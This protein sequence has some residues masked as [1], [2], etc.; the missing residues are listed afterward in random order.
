M[1]SD[2]GHHRRRRDG[3]VVR[4]VVD[5]VDHKIQARLVHRFVDRWESLRVG[6]VRN[7]LVGDLVDLE[8]GPLDADFVL[9]KQAH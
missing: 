6:R 4:T 3:R 7:A 9:D 8:W 1:T 5:V 2:P